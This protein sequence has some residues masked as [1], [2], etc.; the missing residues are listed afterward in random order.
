MYRHIRLDKNIPFYIG[1]GSDNKGNHVRAFAKHTNNPHWMNIV[2]N[3]SYEVEILW[4]DITWDEAGKKELEFIKLYGK[5]TNHSGCLVNLSDGGGGQLGLKWS[6]EQ[7]EKNRIAHIG[8]THTE[9]SKKKMSIAAMGNKKNLG[10]KLSEET[11]IK[12]GLANKV[13]PVNIEQ[14]KKLADLNRGKKHSEETRIKRSLALKGRIMS[15]ETRLKISNTHK[16]MK[17]TIESRLKI[18]KSHIGMKY[19]K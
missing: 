14:I 13:K 10:K 18:S 5:T 1:I 11:K 6:N 19:I 15:P 8:L 12:I 9:E 16:G 4:D 3:T 7:R 17:H 2:K